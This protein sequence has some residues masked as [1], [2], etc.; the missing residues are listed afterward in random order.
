MLSSR[1]IASRNIGTPVMVDNHGMPVGTQL[2][3]SRA[4]M[5]KA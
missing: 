4:A 3:T 5:A 1:S 2:I